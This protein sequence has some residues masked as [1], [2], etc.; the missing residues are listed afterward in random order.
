M[1]K[2]TLS[3]IYLQGILPSVLYGIVIW[4]NC[5]PTLMNSIEKIHTRAARYIHRVKKSTPNTEIMKLVNWSSIE[6]YYKRSL[7]CKAYKIYNNLSSPLLKNLISKT[8]SRRE[9]RNLF[10]VDLPTFKYIDFK[11][12]FS[13]RAA[14]AWNN[15]PNHI[16]EKDSFDCF[17][18]ALRKS[19]ILDKINFNLTG[20][21]LLS[22]DYVY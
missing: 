6:T 21:A 20:R 11:R 7:V 14:I 17:K 8:K 15:T 3:T 1:P 16:R 22:A 19:D 5:A 13:F 10:K 18:Y 9:T 4:G 2:S 12:S